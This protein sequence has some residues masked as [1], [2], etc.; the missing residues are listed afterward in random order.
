MT[1]ET[2]EKG[3]TWADWIPTPSRSN[4]LQRHFLILSD[5]L[6]VDFTITQDGVSGIS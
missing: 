2:C 6:V 1:C 5:L 4:I 3:T